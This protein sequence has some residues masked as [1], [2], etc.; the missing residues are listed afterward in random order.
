MR[1]GTLHAMPHLYGDRKDFDEI[2][3][4]DALCDDIG[5]FITKASE[6]ILSLQASSRSNP[7]DGICYYEVA[8]R[9][10]LLH[11]LHAVVGVVSTLRG[12]WTA[13]EVPF[14]SVMEIMDVSNRIA[15]CEIALGI[16]DPG[17]IEDDPNTSFKSADEALHRSPRTFIANVLAEV[18]RR[19]HTCFH[20]VSG[21]IEN[22]K[23]RSMDGKTAM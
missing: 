4:S 10:C 19:L 14:L 7:S 6:L 9:L 12:L 3:V 8:H 23:S 17:T 18:Q 16:A 13:T 2:E 11:G 15:A 21:A 1:K 22:A 20:V 5:I